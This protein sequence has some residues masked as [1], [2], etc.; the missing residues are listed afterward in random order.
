MS[1]RWIHPG[2]VDSSRTLIIIPMIFLASYIMSDPF[3]H[4]STVG[5]TVILSMLGLFFA[6]SW[7][8]LKQFK[9]TNYLFLYY[10][11]IFIV[12]RFG[13]GLV[14]DYATEPLQSQTVPFIYGAG[15]F[16]YGVG[17]VEA[18]PSVMIQY[19]LIVFVLSVIATN[20]LEVI[21]NQIFASVL[22]LRIR[23]VVVR[24]D[25]F[26]D[27]LFIKF[28]DDYFAI[29]NK[30]FLMGISLFLILG[31]FIYGVILVL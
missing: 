17:P 4:W 18:S 3:R 7:K 26:I 10:V 1:N 21:Y 29:T 15:V 12:L 2:A 27:K 14:L 8:L 16:I 13:L 24:F 20:L 6:F 9:D 11:M 31:L 25:S 28:S 19:A 23:S 5:A 22:P 30:G